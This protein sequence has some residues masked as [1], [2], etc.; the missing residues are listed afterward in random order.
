LK[1]LKVFHPHIRFDP[2]WIKTTG[3]HDLKTSLRTLDKTDF[4]T[5]ELDDKLLNGEIEIAIHSAKDLPDPLPQGLK[6]VAL[7]QGVDP[8][9]ALVFNA[10]ELPF[11]AL[12]GTS[13]HR[14]EEALLKW[15]SD[16]KCVDVRGPVDV[17]LTLLDSGQ[18]DGLV[19]AEAALIRLNLTHRKRML[20][21][22][23]TAP[24]QGRLAVVARVG[25]SQMENFFLPLQH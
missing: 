6:I 16:L 24:L 7:T 5:K 4:F 2:I 11:G 19:V 1:E 20:L 17:R 21:E 9:D 22:G 25:D 13:S 3:D 10:D 23:A 8:S 15:R 18:I 14:R 12:I